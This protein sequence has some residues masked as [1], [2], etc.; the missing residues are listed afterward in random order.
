MTVQPTNNNS[1][2]LLS[3]HHLLMAL[4]GLYSLEGDC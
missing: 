1:Y 2:K 4:G 3:K